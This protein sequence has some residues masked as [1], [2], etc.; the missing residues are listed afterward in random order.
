MAD[1]FDSDK[2]HSELDVLIRYTDI[3][4]DLDNRFRE[5]F[6]P[7]NCTIHRLSALDYSSPV[8]TTSYALKAHLPTAAPEEEDLTQGD[9]MQYSSEEE[10]SLKESMLKEIGIIEKR[11]QVSNWQ[12]SFGPASMVAEKD[13]QVAPVSGDKECLDHAEEEWIPTEKA[14]SYAGSESGDIHPNGETGSKK[15]PTAHSS[16]NSSTNAT[17]P[18]TDEE[19]PALFKRERKTPDCFDGFVFK[20]RRSARIAALLAKSE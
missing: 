20:R 16:G 11:D 18:L 13:A 8:S 10:P 3:E 19:K 7:F 9:I 1:R 2:L 5:P 12:G 15:V 6:S 4:R 17:G 14:T